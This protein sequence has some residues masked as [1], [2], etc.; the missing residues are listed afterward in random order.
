MSTLSVQIL[1]SKCSQESW[2]LYQGFWGNGLLQG[3]GRKRARWKR[4]EHFIVPDYREVLSEY[5]GTQKPT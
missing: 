1:V 3:W 2:L 5:W 4:T